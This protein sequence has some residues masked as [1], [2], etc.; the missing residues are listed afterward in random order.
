MSTV[1]DNLYL[2]PN[3]QNTGTVPPA[4]D[5]MLCP[6]IWCAGTRPVPR[7]KTALASAES[8]STM[9]PEFDVKGRDNYI[10][11]RCRNSTADT[12]DQTQVQLFYTRANG[13]LWTSNWRVVKTES[14]DKAGAIV[15]IPAGGIGV[16]ED[17][18]LWSPPSTFE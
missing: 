9:S 1:S 12:I 17:P 6:D 2:R 7:H 16:V 5:L 15:S 8:Y 3:L 13:I 11:V 4:G 10:Y 14:G 18:F